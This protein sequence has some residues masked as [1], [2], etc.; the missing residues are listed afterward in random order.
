MFK[1]IAQPPA[2]GGTALNAAF[3]PT[4]P[5]APQEIDRASF[6]QVPALDDL[7][8]P[9]SPPEGSEE[10]PQSPESGNGSIPSTPPDPPIAPDATTP[11]T[12]QT[13]AP[14]TPAIPIPVPLPGAPL[15]TTPEDANIIQLTADRQEYDSLRRIFFAEGNAVMRFRGAVIAADRLRVNIPNRTALAQGNVVLTRGQQVIRGSR[16]NYNLTQQDG[17]IADASGEVFIPSAGSDFAATLPTDVSAG[18]TSDVFFSDYVLAEQPLTSVTTTG[19]LT[20]SV[21]GGGRT[22]TSNADAGIQGS[23]N[24]LRFEAEEVDLDGENF[25]AR[26]V[27]LTNDPFSPPELELRSPQVT[28][29]RLSPT[30]SEIRARNPR[31]VFDQGF[32]LPFLRDRL[33]IDERDRNPGLVEFGFDDE[34]RDGF[35]IQRSFEL[36]SLPNLRFTITPQILVQRAI[37]EN[38]TDFLAPSS[39]GLLS[40]LEITPDR[41]TSVE[42]EASISSLDL[43]ALDENTRASIRVRRGIATGL[44][45]HNLTLQYVYRDR[46]FNG[47]LGD[48][49]VQRSLGFVFTSPAILLGTSGVSF[50][51]QAGIQSI[52]ANTDR[53]DLLEPIRDN[54]RVTLGRF[55]A[56]AAVSYPILLWF[57]PP[58]PATRDEGLRYSPVPVTPYVQLF[59]GLRSTTNHYTTGDTQSTLTGTVGIQGQIG[60]F[61]RPFLD[62]TAFNLTYSQSLIAGESPFRFDRDV[63]RQVLAFGILQQIYGPFRAGFQTY[64]SIDQNTRISTDIVLEYSRRTYSVTLRVN[65]VYETGSLSL[66]INDFNWLGNPERFSGAD[67]SAVP[68]GVER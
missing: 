47:S 59:T 11:D 28:F 3:Q 64:I 20:V 39:Y 62:Y 50:S 10:A 56:S 7:V 65:P 22:P 34:D 42:L 14:E 63:D 5:I 32:S 66:Q 67:N 33:I 46:V 60:Y 31:I 48:Q 52:N 23:V 40:R 41:L 17:R 15:P 12:P 8:S 45:R 68:A 25:V 61:S 49:E 9:E 51:Y 13:P 30:R 1:P 44:G 16:F 21:G 18:A 57:R 27:R 35:Y 24:R 36:L 29:T 54:N 55:Q 6:S 58:L 43:D 53:Q 2:F 37:F 4:Y 26:N 19:G 38:S